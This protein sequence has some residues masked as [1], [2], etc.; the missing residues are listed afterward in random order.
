MDKEKERW[1]LWREV[2]KD[3][4]AWYDREEV[5]GRGSGWKVKEE[6][7]AALEAM[8]NAQQK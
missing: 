6:A 3:V 7:T 4:V 8:Y 5:G 2:L 1:A